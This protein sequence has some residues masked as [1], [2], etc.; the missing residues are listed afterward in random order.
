M[1]EVSLDRF[2]VIWQR[3]EEVGSEGASTGATSA[4]TALSQVIEAWELD[5]TWVMS[6]RRLGSTGRAKIRHATRDRQKK[7]T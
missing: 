4:V 7:V 1:G 2:Y 3:D 6:V 5:P